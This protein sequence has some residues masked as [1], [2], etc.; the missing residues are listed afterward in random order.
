MEYM[1]AVVVH[2]YGDFRYER[3]PRPTTG[4]G[5]VV[6]RTGAA[7]ICAADRKFYTHGPW[8]LKFPFITGHE[9]VGTVFE[10]GE[11]AGEKLGLTVG[12]M[13]VV[14]P[15]V[16]CWECY[17]CKRG[18]YHL[19]IEPSFLGVTL[20]GG[21]AEFVKLP[22]GSLVYRVPE[23]LSFAEAAMAEPVSC[24]VYAVERADIGLNDVVIVSGLGPIG[25]SMLQ[26]VKLKNPRLI[27][28]LDIN[29]PIG[30]IAKELG[31]DYFLN[32]RQAN[33][34]AEISRLTDGLGCDVYL[35]AS[36]YTDS[37]E[38]GMDVLRKQGKLFIYGVYGSKASLDFNQVSE[39]KELQIIGGHLSPFMFPLAICY[40][41]DGQVNAK[42]M[43]THSF[44]LENFREALEIKKVAKEPV[45]KVTLRPSKA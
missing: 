2:A 34:P 10:L 17:Y 4:P 9:I 3:V 14:E 6:I 21:W 32:V 39:F 12:D 7:G 26:V 22:L 8:A 38:L 45:I 13:V 40:L 43:I 44:D 36:G 20:D 23:H 18:L 37:I 16:P 31:A 11:G 25:M 27:I 28:A 41:A 30:L 33:I 19:C 15:I 1:N 29:D 5:E 42:K 35:E 24:A